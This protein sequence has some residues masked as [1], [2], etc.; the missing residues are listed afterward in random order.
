MSEERTK[1]ENERDSEDDE[2]SKPE[3][4]EVDIEKLSPMVSLHGH[5]WTMQ[6]PYLICDSCQLRHSFYI[7]MDKILVGYDESGNPILKKRF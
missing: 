3:R 7:G 1:N 4:Y 6:G 5:R 2:A